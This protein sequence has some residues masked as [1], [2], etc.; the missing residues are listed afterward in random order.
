MRKRP[1][2]RIMQR[3]ASP[4]VDIAAQIFF[5][6]SP[7]RVVAKKAGAGMLYYLR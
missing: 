5:I 2:R 1:Q 3:F 4:A 7:L 6:R